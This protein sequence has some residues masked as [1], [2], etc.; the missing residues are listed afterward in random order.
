MHRL[1]FVAWLCWILA[2]SLPAWAGPASVVLFDGASVAAV[3]YDRT[4]GTP[5]R[6]AAELLSRDLTGLSGR[7]PAVGDETGSSTGNLVIIGLAKSPQIAALLK[8]SGISADPIK[9]KWESYGRIVVPSPGNSRAK[10]L[11]IFGSDVRGTIWGV[12]DLTREMGVSPWEWWADV[13]VRKVSHIAVAADLR[14]SKEPSVKYRGFFINADQ[15]TVWAA[16]TYDPAA[17]GLGPKTYER[18]FELMWRLKA[19][20]LWPAMGGSDPPFNAHP[21]NYD[22]A[23]DYA[24]LR[25]SSHVE[26]LLRANG[27]EWDEKKRGP[28]N[29]VVNKKSMIEY[30]REIVEKF[31]SYDNLYTVGLRGADDFPMDGADTPEKTADIVNDAIAEQRKI[32]SQ[33]IG[34]SAGEVPQIFTP[35]KEITAAYNTGRI[36]LPDDITINW[37]DDNFGYVMQFPSPTER[38]RSGGAGIYYHTTFWGAPNAYILL[39]STD[40]ALMWEEMTKAYHFGACTHWVL[41]VGSIKPNEVLTEFFLAMA[42]DIDAF[43]KSTSVHDWF[44]A[45][46]GRNFGAA[47]GDEI[48]D[49]MSLYYRLAF[50]RNPEF[51]A[52][53]TTFPET[54]VHQTRFNIEDFGDENTRRADAYRA[55][56]ARASNLMAV[57]PEDRKS[58]FYQLVQYTVEVGG[59]LNLQ[60]LALDKAVTYGLQ[61]RASADVYAEEANRA[62]QAIVAH[63]NRYNATLEGGKW[64]GFMVDYPQFLPNYE[65]P[66]VP[67]WKLPTNWSRCGVQV[68]GGGYF[69]DKGWWY[70][71][72]PTFQRELAGRS[73]Y[74]DVFSEQAVAAA[75]S[76]KPNAPWIKLDRGAGTFSLAEKRYE[77]RIRVSIDWS[78]APQTG[79]GTITVACSAGQKP[80]DV[81]V[82]IAPPLEDKAVSFVDAQGVVSMYAAHADAMSGGWRVLRG[83]GHTGADVQADVD[84]A[85]IESADRAVLEKAPKLVYRFATTPQDRDY[86]FPNYVLDEVATL[87]V[88][89]LPSF[90]VAKDGKLR[91]AVSLD[92]GPPKVLDFS[93][94]Y[95]GARWRQNVLDNAAVAE[96]HDLAVK[97]GSHTL[98]VWALDPSVTLDRFELVFAGA[99]QAYGPIPETRIPR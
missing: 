75:W 23:R 1:K 47:H 50:D 74:M 86:S 60:Q 71:T 7:T 33:A 91:I 51:M 2:L 83:V 54:A 81:H 17:H 56:M 39:A 22:M 18:V 8:K 85:P 79:E 52:F 10:A 3:S 61:H 72:L 57:M 93:V 12:I 48:A 20:M 53:T 4:G 98:S 49:I 78:K 14:Y 73:Y 15:L 29:W 97:P 94:R 55:I 82:R 31:G 46:A 95:Y 40:P 88:V 35:Y 19:N 70:P 89:A 76:A 87:R 84:M 26:M 67:H 66:A 63:A 44:R 41:N 30:W 36:K 28:Y 25:G 96:L 64:N 43:E 45:W 27:Y 65:P 16:K 92:G 13:K 24:V 21:E 34:K 68:E 6:K 37:P 80:V 32:L 77:Q 38:K 9:G 5:I 62:H 99:S 11:V 42:F 59:S 90:P 69:D 58:A